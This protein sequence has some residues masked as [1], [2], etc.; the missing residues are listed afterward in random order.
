[1]PV[2]MPGPGEH[3]GEAWDTFRALGSQ[4]PLD[5]ARARLDAVGQDD[6]SDIIFTSGTTGRPKGVM[7]RHGTSLVGFTLVNESY[8]LGEHDRYMIPTPFFHCFGYK[9]GWMLSLMTGATTFPLAVFDPEEVLRSIARER[10]TFLPGSPT[11]FS[12]LLDHPRRGDYDL[13]SLRCAMVS[14]ASVPA[15]LVRRMRDELALDRVFTG[16]GLTENHA[17]VSFTQ[18]G[19]PPEVVANTVGKLIP[20]LEVRIVDDNGN[21]RP[22]GEQGEILIRGALHM[23][24]Y[25][26]DEEATAKTIV[27]GWLH[28]GDIGVIDEHDYMRITDR[29]KD[30]FIVGGF[31]VAPAE[32][33]RALLELD[34]IAQVAVIGIPD[35][36]YGEVGAAFVIPH[37]G[38]GLTADEVIA[39]AKDH[40][41]NYKVPRTVLIVDGFPLNATGK[42]L[43]SELRSRL[44]P[45]LPAVAGVRS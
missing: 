20:G 36:Y 30:M 35:D 7:L 1:M 45:S 22:L 39:Y 23:S 28:T 2:V 33:E 29:K 24:G 3:G 14:T 17:L 6:I 40:L 34:A 42:V 38:S 10:I 8:G 43:K 16:Y 18:P 32:V 5:A 27:D 13:S 41:A 21:D 9:S 11:M 26:R 19:D 15:P 31:N 37:E 4:V 44:Q 25:Y 12:A